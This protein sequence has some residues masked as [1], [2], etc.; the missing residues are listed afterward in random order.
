MGGA[1]AYQEPLSLHLCA[2]H[3][4]VAHQANPVVGKDDD[5]D[6]LLSAGS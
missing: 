4:V 5:V 6:Q 3:L 2:H 1:L